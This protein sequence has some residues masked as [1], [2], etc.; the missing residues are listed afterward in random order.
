MPRSPAATCTVAAIASANDSVRDSNGDSGH[1][2]AKLPVGIAKIRDLRHH[3]ITN[4][5]KHLK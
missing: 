1:L 5:N 3:Y 4:K 2:I